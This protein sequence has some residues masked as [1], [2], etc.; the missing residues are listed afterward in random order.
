MA[1]KHYK[2]GLVIIA[3]LWITVLLNVIVVTLARSSLLDA[4][5]SR[6]MRVEQ[7]RCKWA[8]RA[9]LEKAVAVLNEDLRESD[10]LTDLWSDNAEDFNDIYLQDCW[11][12]V[13]VIDEAGKL[14]INTATKD[15]LL[16]LEYMEEDVVDSIL[17]WRD[18]DEN[19]RTQGVE[20]GYYENM[21]Y[22]YTIRNDSFKTIRELLLVKGVSEELFYGEDTNFNGFLD[23]HERD[24]DATPPYDD[25]DDELD[26]GWIEY[27]TC[28]SYDNNMD[29]EG[30]RK[31][32]I[33]SGNERQ[34]ERSLGIKR[35]NAKWIV[36]NRPNNGYSSIGD[37]INKN[38]PEQPSGSQTSGSGQNQNQAEPLDMQT[39]Y[40]IADKITVSNDQQIA[41]KININTA[42]VDVL[43]TLLGDDDVA[44]QLAQ[45]I[46]A[47]RDT[48]AYGMESIAE[49]MQ[50]PSMTT[51]IFK[52][53][54][55]DITTRSNVFTI[56]CFATAD[57]NGPAG[58]KLQTEAVIDRSTSPCK[59]LYWYQG[60]NY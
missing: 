26:K 40:E 7:L 14:N 9:A 17:D 27:L 16:C 35:S 28:H 24:G 50:V 22:R 11:F 33:N 54:A 32:N 37:L 5:V 56:R 8:C 55:N 29:V 23:Y 6:Q 30:N 58:M 13:R 57:R 18:K 15:Q 45:N 49:V 41:G 48:L 3:V 10:C 59:V 42:S 47:Y 43:T 44:L 21:P 34:L 25:K 46:V 53:I 20:G 31:V 51:D 4:K 38:T 19:P 12:N 2:K 39:F 36:D 60:A 1:K 52:K